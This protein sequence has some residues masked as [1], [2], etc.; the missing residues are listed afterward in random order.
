MR[1]AR[2]VSKFS[3][4][5]KLHEVVGFRVLGFRVYRVLGF[6]VF[7]VYETGSGAPLKG[8]WWVRG[9]GLW[10]RDRAGLRPEKP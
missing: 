7:G 8:A 5:A 9:A 4:L 1:G 2:D 6:R 3:V 10:L